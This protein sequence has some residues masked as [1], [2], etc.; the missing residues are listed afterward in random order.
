[1]TASIRVALVGAL[2]R[3]GGAVLRMIKDRPDLHLTAAVERPGPAVGTDVGICAGLGP[4]HVVLSDAAE[5]V[6]KEV[7]V[8]IDFSAPPAALLIA[9]ICAARRFAYL[10]ASTGLSDQDL[11]AIK[12]ASALAPVLCAANLSLGVNVMMGLVEKA[13]RELNTDFDVEILEMHH[14]RKKDAPSGTA[15]KLA[16]A[17]QAA[18]PAIDLVVG[19]RG[20]TEGR[21]SQDL[22]IASLRGGDVSGDHTVFFLGKNERLEITH[23]AT[24]ADVFAQGALWIAGWLCR[25]PAGLYSVRDVLA[26]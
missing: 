13:A 11:A 21:G 6:L 5:A 20:Q 19:R 3:M 14:R 23:R 25:Q 18:R 2:G 4:V 26:S 16:A 7:D 1:V 22:G 9:P 24:S 15:L 10:V 12:Q 8:V 17:V